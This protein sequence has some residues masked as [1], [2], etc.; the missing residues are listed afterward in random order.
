MTEGIKQ[1]KTESPESAAEIQV[2]LGIK[3]AQLK[4]LLQVTHAIN[5]NF[6]NQQ[7]LDIF[8]KVM[9]EEGLLQRYPRTKP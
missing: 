2:E 7:L 9:Q 4:W 3:N 6:S 8:E 1:P 5:Y